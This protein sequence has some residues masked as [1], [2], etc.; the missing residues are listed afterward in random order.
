MGMQNRSR[1][2][3]RGRRSCTAS[4]GFRTCRRYARPSTM[5]ADA[6]TSFPIMDDSSWKAT[7]CRASAR[8]K[9]RSNTKHSSFRLSG[10]ILSWCRTVS[11]KKPSSSNACPGPSRFTTF[12]VTPITSKTNAPSVTIS[13]IHPFPAAE[14]IKSSTYT[15]EAG[16]HPDG[17]PPDRGTSPSRGT[18]EGF[19]SH[20][21]RIS[22]W[23]NSAIQVVFRH[24]I[25]GLNLKPM[26]ST[27]NTKD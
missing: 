2:R 4:R 18:T 19:P 26:G 8:S 10:G 22:A 9:I 6:H 23:I 21:A 13:S 7:D 12:S 5:A 27:G 16:G 17:L 1:S 15:L 25:G 14:C 20:L 3:R 11:N 24:A